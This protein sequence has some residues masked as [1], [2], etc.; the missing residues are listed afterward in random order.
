MSALSSSRMLVPIDESDPVL[1]EL[2]D[3]PTAPAGLWQSLTVVADPRKKR[4]VRHRFT[5]IIAIAMA[6]TIAGAR[7]YVAIAQWAADDGA[8]Q[9]LEHG[10]GVDGVPSESAIRRTLQRIAVDQLESVIGAWMWLRTTMIDGRRVIAFDGKTLRGARSKSGELTHLLAGLCQR[11][12]V[13]VGQVEVGAKTNEIPTLR[14]LLA[15]LD[16][17]G[18]VITADAMQS[19]SSFLCMNLIPDFR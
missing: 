12:G 16:I 9:L 4:G 13:V 15:T 11:S 5:T 3:V 2:S 10:I 18:A 14:A 8:A 17:T 19:L 6:A 1:G 7:S